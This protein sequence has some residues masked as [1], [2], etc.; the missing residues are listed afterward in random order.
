MTRLMH[1]T[2]VRRAALY[3]VD[4]RGSKALLH[5]GENLEWARSHDDVN[6]T[7]N[8]NQ[9]LMK[10]RTFEKPLEQSGVDYAR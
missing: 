3:L 1:E 4:Q 10:I 5:A 2:E 9:I 7:W 6:D 8:W